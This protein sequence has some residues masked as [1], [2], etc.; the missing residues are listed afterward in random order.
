V[1]DIRAALNDH[2]RAHLGA[3]DPSQPLPRRQ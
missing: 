2:A 3:R 1:R